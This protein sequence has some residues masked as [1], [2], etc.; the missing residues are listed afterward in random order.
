M[1]TETNT[2]QKRAALESDKPLDA[3]AKERKLLAKHKGCLE[4]DLSSA[5]AKL[6]AALRRMYGVGQI[7]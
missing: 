3:T 7:R 6:L 2:S 5:D 1:P 4:E